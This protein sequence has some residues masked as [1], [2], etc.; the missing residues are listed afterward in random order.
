M[1]DPTRSRA[2]E[3][4]AHESRAR[5]PRRRRAPA[6]P[7]PTVRLLEGWLWFAG[8][9]VALLALALLLPEP[10]GAQI[11]TGLRPPERV[12]PA[13]Q[14]ARAE[15]TITAMRD[16]AAREERLDLRAWVDSAA[17]SLEAGAAPVTPMPDVPGDSLVPKPG[18]PAPAP[19]PGARPDA[20]RDE[21]TTSFREGA[22]APD[23]AT[24][25][26]LLLAV[27]GAMV[28]S[29]IWLRRRR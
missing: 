11:T 14:V 13:Q 25:L 21:P 16:S 28:G 8:L 3:S 7:P 6:A 19:R 26:P 24:P 22:P 9:L 17:M 5:E 27:G 10:V 4:R 20:G 2:H 1:P 12:T 29:G 18:V 15:S 23:T